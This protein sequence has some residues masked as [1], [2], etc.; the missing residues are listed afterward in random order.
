ME[1]PLRV[2]GAGVSQDFDWHAIAPRNGILISGRL[3][4]R[5]EG[6]ILTKP[7]HKIVLDH[8]KRLLAARMRQGGS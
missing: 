3:V 7:Y 8:V 2:S 4:G 1:L 6:P 5:S